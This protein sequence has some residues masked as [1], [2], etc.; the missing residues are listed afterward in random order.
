MTKFPM[1]TSWEEL[2]VAEFPDGI[3]AR[4]FSIGQVQGDEAAPT[5]S[6]VEL[7]AG[8][9]VATHPD[10]CDNSELLREVA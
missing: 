8:R 9:H 2:D 10:E 1:S 3:R 5:V 7:P 4:W 6:L